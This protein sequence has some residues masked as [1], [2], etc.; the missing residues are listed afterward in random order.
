MVHF[1]LD[2]AVRDAK[3]DVPILVLRVS[4]LLDVML[5]YGGSKVFGNFGTYKSVYTSSYSRQQKFSEQMMGMLL[6]LCKSHC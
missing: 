6:P 3:I 4:F 2:E 5:L 1:V